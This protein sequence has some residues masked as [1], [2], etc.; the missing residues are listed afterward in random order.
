MERSICWFRRDLRIHDNPAL[1]NAVK[2]GLVLPIYILDDTN[3][4]VYTIGAASKVWL[5]HSLI[6]LNKKLKGN[7]LVKNFVTTFPRL[8]CFFQ[9][10]IA[11]RKNYLFVMLR[12]NALHIW[13]QRSCYY[14]LKRNNYVPYT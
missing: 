14:K 4:G 2:E 7:L 1:Y 5:H 9:D 3:S 11:L 13:F 12:N 8:Y 10:E 6:A